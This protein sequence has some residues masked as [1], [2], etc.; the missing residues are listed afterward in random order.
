MPRRRAPTARAASSSGSGP[1]DRT[2]PAAHRHPRTAGTPAAHPAGI[3]A[4]R[5]P[6]AAAR[7]RRRRPRR[8]AHSR[9][10][11]RAKPASARSVESGAIGGDRDARIDRARRRP[12]A[13][14]RHRPPVPLSLRPAPGKHAARRRRQ[15]GPQAV[16]QQAVLDDPAQFAAPQRIGIE[17]QFAAAGRHPTPACGDRAA[18]AL[19][20]CRAQHARSCFEQR[21]VVG[22]EGIHAQVRLRCLPA[23]RR[24]AFD[25]RDCRARAPANA[26]AQALP[27][28]PPPTTATSSRPRR[29]MRCP[30]GTARH[31]AAIAHRAA[32]Q[33]RLQ[34]MASGPARAGRALRSG[35]SSGAGSAVSRARPSENASVRVAVFA[36]TLRVCGQQRRRR[37][38]RPPAGFDQFGQGQRIAQAEVE[39][40]RAERDARSARHC[41]PAPRASR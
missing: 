28:T 18:R 26:S 23:R 37:R 9:G 16:D 5:C 34:P 19:R 41:R 8:A 31:V 33:P 24:D 30:R 25:Q 10:D 35:R 22:R 3:A 7:C 2:V 17:H 21:G 1:D 6:R 4:R 15:R 11:R 32:D 39:S 12:A 27:T 40:L 29:L 36:A 38:D 14:A 13:G 20:G